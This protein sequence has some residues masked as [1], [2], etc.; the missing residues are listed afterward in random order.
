MQAAGIELVLPFW[1][2]AARAIPF[3]DEP[4]VIADYGASQG[5][6]SMAPI[7]MAIAA[8][9]E[10]AGAD[11]PV[12]VIHTDL[13]SN[14]YAS[15]F[16]T[17]DADPDSYMA[18]ATGVFPSA[19][20]RSYFD[21]ILPTG[22]VHLAWNSWT[23][24]WMRRKIDAPDHV[25]ARHTARLDVGAAVTAQLAAD[26]RQFL[27]ARSAELRTGARLVTLFTAAAGPERLG[28]DWIGRELWS[29]VVAM[30][31]D[32]LLSPEEQLRITVPVGQRTLAEIK[33]PFVDNGRFAG[34]ELQHAAILD[35][36]DP[37]WPAFEASGDAGQFG[38][39][40]A[41]M[42]RAVTGPTILAAIEPSRDGSVV[43]DD[44][45][46]RLA[47]RLA[48]APQRHEHYFAV[49]VMT[50]TAAGSA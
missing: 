10:R 50:R 46:D 33:A 31:R 15:L 38:R 14:D 34:F 37:F 49:V 47:A 3:A 22:R 36:P 29:S 32:G 40:L 16:T 9:R 27:Q 41:D 12:E 48:A 28:W 43:L 21:Q 23:L 44:L 24:H 2:E 4:L 8:L 1:T 42:C 6:N 20:G 5:R 25:W 19:V 26:W 13:P 18:G 17:L 11:R 45:F 39:S 30:G 35:G 7:R